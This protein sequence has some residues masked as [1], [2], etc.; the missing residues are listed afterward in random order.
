MT[1]LLPCLCDQK[2][3]SQIYSFLLFQILFLHSC[4]PLLSDRERWF[5]NRIFLKI[6][7]QSSEVP[8]FGKNTE[9]SFNATQY[10]QCKDQVVP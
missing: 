5:E 10:L 1:K 8:G 7:V 4:V 2:R 3:N 9:L 6:I